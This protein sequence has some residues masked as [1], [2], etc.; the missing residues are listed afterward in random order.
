MAFRKKKQDP[1]HE[2][3]VCLQ[4]RDYKGALDWFNTLLQKDPKNTQIRLRFADTLVLSGNKREAVKQ[5]GIVADELAEKGFMIRAIAINKKILQLDPRQTDVHDKLAAMSQ[6][7]TSEA[8]TRP[9]LEELLHRPND[10]LRRAEPPPT[11]RSKPAPTPP[12]P[13]P[14]PPETLPELS[15]E[16]SMA[17]EFGAGGDLPGETGAD[18]AS[19]ASDEA[20]S[21][22]AEIYSGGL[23]SGRRRGS[24]DV[25]ACS[26]Q[27]ASGY[28]RRRSPELR[29]RAHRDLGVG[30]RG[31]R[32]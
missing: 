2:I 1:F 29:R 18:P 21:A 12:P 22:P 4:K 23:D 9:A 31:R 15:L 27:P 10:P 26:S 28:S 5:F 7:R 8:S 11:E 30:A 14:S 19:S 24:A 16:E 25:G 32:D 20:Q 6:D 3:Q 13:A 17:M